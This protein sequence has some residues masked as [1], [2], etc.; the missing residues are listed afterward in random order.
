MLEADGGSG[1]GGLVI[2]LHYPTLYNT[3]EWFL[4]YYHDVWNMDT[5]QSDAM[6]DLF[7]K[8]KGWK[9]GKENG[10]KKHRNHRTR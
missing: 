9:G 2:W 1:G 10:S 3:A 5:A 7:I 8:K 4:D 6:D